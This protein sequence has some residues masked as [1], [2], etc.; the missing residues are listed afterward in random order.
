MT[1]KKGSEKRE[2]L[3]LPTLHF[4][5]M[6][7]WL[8]VIGEKALL[9]WLKMYTWCDR[10]RT[11]GDKPADINLWEQS[12]IPSSYKEVMKKLGVGKDTFY[13]KILKPLWNVGLIDIEEWAEDPRSGQ[14]AMNI[15]VY[16]YPQNDKPLSFRQLTAIRDYDTEYASTTRSFAKKG[17][18]PR[19]EEAPSSEEQKPLTPFE[20]RRFSN[21][22]GGGSEIE[23]GVVGS[24]IEPG[25]FPTRTE[26]GS[27]IG[28]NNSPNTSFNSFN[29]FNSLKNEEEEGA[30]FVI[31]AFKEKINQN[32]NSVIEGELSTWTQKLP[33]EVII[34]EIDYA[35]M[36]GKDT[37]TFIQ[38]MLEQDFENGI[39]TVEKLLEKRKTFKRTVVRPVKHPQNDSKHP[40]KPIREEKKP[41]WLGQEEKPHVPTEEE[42]QRNIQL[43]QEKQ[44][45][46]ANMRL[47]RQ[48]ASG[49]K[50]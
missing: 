14:K 17:G 12:K 48:Q 5:V 15:I 40:R 24:E 43:E 44:E 23:P 29:S 33:V 35:A 26:G 18:R 36:K 20:E 31:S 46:I 3:E 41:T 32:T 34:M 4:V 45:M 1:F 10:D 16:K 6:D 9:S 7:Q 30:K 28:D 11:K 47:K 2:E 49:Q 8:D 21:R 42:I 50:V 39:D 19:K 38:S 27:E 13:N 25:G 22:T 37:Y